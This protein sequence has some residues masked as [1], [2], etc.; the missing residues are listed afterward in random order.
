MAKKLAKKSYW[1]SVHKK[2]FG[3]VQS[4]LL[5]GL[6]NYELNLLVKKYAKKAKAKTIFEVGC[7]PANYL[8]AF[9][10]QFNLDVAGVEYSEE[11]MKKIEE[12]FSKNN[13]KGKIFHADF[14]DDAFLKKNK[15]KYDIVYSIG[16]IEHFDNPQECIDRHF[17]LVKESGYVIIAIP[18]L[19]SIYK[20]FLSKELIDSHNLTI[21][22]K[23]S[24]KTYFKQYKTHE[25]FYCGGLLNLGLLTYKNKILDTLRLFFFLGQRLIFDPFMIGLYKLGFNFSNSLTSPQLI[26]VCS[27]K[28]KSIKKKK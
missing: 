12:N 10:K 15:N 19:R 9:N 6:Q 4:P 17:A 3:Y 5:Q 27:K 22:E 2:G 23:T 8:I 20:P 14:F 25:L 28:K 18:N 13:V 21:M 7:A 26:I 24:L 11:G 16:F 1:D